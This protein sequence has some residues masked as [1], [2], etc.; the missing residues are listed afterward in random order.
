M[1]L[2][3]IYMNLRLYKNALNATLESIKIKPDNSSSYINLC[4]IYRRLDDMPKAIE[5][6]DFAIKLDPDNANANLVSGQIS[7][8][9]GEIAKAEKLLLKSIKLSN[10]PSRGL[11]YLSIALYLKG[12][13]DSSLKSIEKS[14]ELDPI[15]G[16]SKEIEAIIRGKVKDARSVL[17]REEKPKS[18]CIEKKHFPITLARPVEE[19]LVK[20]LYGLHHVDH[21][22]R[23]LPTKGNAKT[24]NFSFFEENV[25]LVHS[26]KQDL[27][28]LAKGAIGADI[29]FYDSWFTIL[30]GGGHV[31][32]HNHSSSLSKIKG[33]ADPCK[34]FA[35]VY[36]L[37]I[38]DQA[39]EEPG[40]LKFYDPE[41]YV[42]PIKG[43]IIIFPADRYHSVS[44][45][46]SK[47]R[48]MIG[49]NFWS[50]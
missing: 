33:F 5:A 36:Y 4:E 21:A 37:S 40:L 13:Y 7:L 50:I 26:L 46:G 27:I 42:V 9:L 39:G 23:N 12:D 32:K 48:I 15:C 49:A 35:L 1:N 19:E 17:L 38:G 18:T 24:S 31:S 47:D 8:E 43:M 10:N 45:S 22:K 14:I 3:A 11:R 29:H 2:G 16:H 6:I 25:E 41:E 28:S 30:R 20:S 34:N 44:Y